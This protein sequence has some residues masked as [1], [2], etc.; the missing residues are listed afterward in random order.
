M[1]NS[2]WERLVKSTIYVNDGV[3][4]SS[5]FSVASCD[6]YFPVCVSLIAGHQVASF[7]TMEG[8]YTC[9]IICRRLA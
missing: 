7:R 8:H 6:E 4:K 5:T 3:E 2:V 1:T 9:N